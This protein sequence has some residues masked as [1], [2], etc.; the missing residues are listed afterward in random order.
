PNAA[1]DSTTVAALGESRPKLS[2]RA[3]LL[4]RNRAFDG[5][6][7]TDRSGGKRSSRRTYMVPD[8]TLRRVFFIGLWICIQTVVLVYKWVT[9]GQKAKS[10]FTGFSSAAISCMMVSYAAIFLFMSPTLLEL[11]RRT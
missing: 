7:I 8:I 2:R 11:L 9:E 3:S 10:A 5:Y 6:K 4:T 1:Q